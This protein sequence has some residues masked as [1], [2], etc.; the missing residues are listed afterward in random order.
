MLFKAPQDIFTE[1]KKK[2]TVKTHLQNESATCFFFFFLH[3]EKNRI[4]LNFKCIPEAY[5]FGYNNK[6][7][8]TLFKDTDNRVL[9]L[10]A[11]VG[12]C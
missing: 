9:H 8:F 7:I 11:S 6:H 10:C 12:W 1:E 5:I 3:V 4:Y 2:R